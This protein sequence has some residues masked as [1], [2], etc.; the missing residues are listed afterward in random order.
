MS[1][2]QLKFAFNISE[3]SQKFNEFPA[4]RV[5]PEHHVLPGAA[6][7]DRLHPGGALDENQRTGGTK[8][9]VAAYREII[10]N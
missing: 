6:F 2:F 1:E 9:S 10:K 8:G 4:V 3:F 5:H 7:V